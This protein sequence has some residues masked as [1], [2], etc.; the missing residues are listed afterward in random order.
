[1]NEVLQL[2]VVSIVG[3]AFLLR[4]L[5]QFLPKMVWRLR[6]RLSYEFEHSGRPGWLRALGQRLR[7]VEVSSGQ[8]C[9]T[10][11]SSCGG[12]AVKPAATEARPLHFQTRA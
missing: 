2:A 11:C 12:C 4:A 9:G 5:Q 6:A 10:G 1:V 3:L 7:P 8:G